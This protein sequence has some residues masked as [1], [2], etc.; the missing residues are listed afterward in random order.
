[1]ITLFGERPQVIRYLSPRRGRNVTL[2]PQ[3]RT[4]LHWAGLARGTRFSLRAL[5]ILLSSA[6]STAG[7]KATAKPSLSLGGEL[8][9]LLLVQ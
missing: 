6:F 1:M 2:L 8:E 9:I 7:G 5:R 3:Q 4:K